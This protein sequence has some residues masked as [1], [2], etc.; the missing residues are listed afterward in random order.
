MTAP[1]LAATGLVRRYGGL[2]ALDQVSLEVPAGQVTAL[3]GPNGA[4]KTT[5]F[6][7]LTGAER[8]DAGRVLLAG[9][10]VTRLRPEQRARAGLARTFQR[11]AVF[12]QMSVLDNLLVAAERGPRTGLLADLLRIRQRDDPAAVQLAEQVL[13]LVGL[14]AERH[15]LA[16]SLPAGTQRR[17]ELARALCTRPK[18]L[19]LDEPASGLDEAETDALQAV[20]GQV[21]RTG[22]GVLLVEHDVQLVLETSA[23]V[24]V[25]AAGRLVGQGPPQQVRND[26]AVLAAYLGPP[27]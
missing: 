10:D 14:T 26:P 7:C 11:L 18:V 17:V 23:Y 24:Y 15:L 21:A 2:T 22:V 1:A 16:A 8:A 3:I 6:Q 27:P 19:L 5:V 12:G 20:L 9:R 4:G 25:L 13:E